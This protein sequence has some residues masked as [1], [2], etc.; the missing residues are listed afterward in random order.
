MST[1]KTAPDGPMSPVILVPL[2]VALAGTWGSLYLSMG[3]GLKACPLCFYQRTFMMSALAVLVMGWL[4]DR[5][6]GTLFCLLCVPLSIGG[7]GVAGFHE[8]LVV[9]DKLECPP[10]A[11]GVGTAPA[12]SL[13]IFAALT[14][15]VVWG[16]WQKAVWIPGGVLL[17]IVLAWAC[18]ASAPPMP[19]GPTKPYDKP[20]D[21]CRPPFRATASDRR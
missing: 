14:V 11:F 2:L 6:Q 10:G 12:Q 8:Y 15:V 9:T 16:A 21:I 4:A 3:L 1:A 19:P 18:V 17:G 20:P 7:L 5:T 13:A